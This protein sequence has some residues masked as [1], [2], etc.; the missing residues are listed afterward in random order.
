MDAFWK[1]L[2]WQQFGA[3]IDMLEN[4]MNACPDA[5]WNDRSRQPEFWYVVYHTL[6]LLDL[7][8]SDSLDGFAP[9]PPVGMEELDPDGKMP[10]RP[11]TKDEMR[12]YLDHGRRKARER[13][14][15]MTGEKAHRRCGIEWHTISE[16][17]MF[18][19]NMRHVQHH[20]A[21][22]NLILRQV[23]DSAPKWVRKAG[24]KRD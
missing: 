1:A 18:L 19:Y 20:A 12:A 15:N 10:E 7:Y 8:S 21:Q 13:I 3:A 5:L 16:A 17:E 2:I 4:A 23:T 24:E 11:Y 22:L 6:F 14:E 9:P